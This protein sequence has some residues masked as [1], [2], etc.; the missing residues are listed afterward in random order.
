MPILSKQRFLSE[1]TNHTIYAPVRGLSY[2]VA[3]AG[4]TLSPK[5]ANLQR[6]CY[7][8]AREYVELCERS[9]DGAE[10]AN[11][12][13]FQTLMFI[14][15]YELTYKQ[16]TRAWMTL[17]RAITL[18][19][20]LHLQQMDNTHIGSFTWDPEVQLKPME[21]I[22]SMEEIRR[23]FWALYILDC[24]ASIRTKRPDQF[25]EMQVRTVS[26]LL[27]HEQISCELR[28]CWKG[29]GLL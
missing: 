4:S 24:Y 27:L 28:L 18:A 23:S 9:D 19:K 8:K 10:L 11:L 7:S 25:G 13:V 15:R 6:I 29:H 14:I 22:T 12:N 16:L 17:G 20:M 2:G 5:S 1:L 3:L 26:S 21:N